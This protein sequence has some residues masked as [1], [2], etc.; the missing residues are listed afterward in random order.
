[1]DS[2]ARWLAIA[3]GFDSGIRIGQLVLT[4]KEQEDHTLRAEAVTVEFEDG[5][6]LG[7]GEEL[8]RRL[9]RGGRVESMDLDFSSNKTG[10]AGPLVVDIKTVGRR[11]TIESQVLDDLCA[12]IRMSGVKEGDQFLTRYYEARRKVLTRKEV[13][14]EIKGCALRWGLE[15]SLFSSKSLRK[16]FSSHCDKIG[17]DK[18]DR[19]RRGSWAPGS[20][21]PETHYVSK[22]GDMGGLA[23]IGNG[24]AGIQVGEIRRLVAAGRR[25]K[26]L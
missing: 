18:E 5:V 9:I 23:R 2:K 20:R 22:I 14:E 17:V 25:A 19:N 12:W 16:G 26:G 21:V 4:E 8:R 13:N 24:T 7:I 11:S 3:L 1:M 6:S 15:G 10:R